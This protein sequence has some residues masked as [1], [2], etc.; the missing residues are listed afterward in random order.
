[1]AIRDFYSTVQ[2]FP[3][4]GERVVENAMAPKRRLRSDSEDEQDDLETQDQDEIEPSRSK[5]KRVS[6][7]KD[8]D[9]PED[10]DEDMEEDGLSCSQ[11]PDFPVS[12]TVSRVA[13][14]KPVHRQAASDCSTTSLKLIY[15][16]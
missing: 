9:N 13:C 4:T 8:D 11:M 5:K 12:L 3:C 2:V 14:G 10:M 15:D 6:S 1:M 7:A 16:S